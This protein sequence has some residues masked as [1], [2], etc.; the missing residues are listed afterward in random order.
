MSFFLLFRIKEDSLK[1]AGKQTVVVAIDLQCLFFIL[2][3]SMA[4]TVCYP[5]LFKIFFVLNR[6]KK[7][8]TWGWVND[9]IIFIFGQTLSLKGII[10]PKMDFINSLVV[11]VMY[12]VFIY[13]F[14]II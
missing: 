2:W 13:I 4:T 14:S 9:D 7:P 10:H 12:A 5:T 6:R 1:N 3:K 11:I 8:P